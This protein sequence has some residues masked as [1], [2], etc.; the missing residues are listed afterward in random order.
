MTFDD[1]RNRNR[2]QGAG[3]SPSGPAIPGRDKRFRNR[4]S[5][6]RGLE[7]FLGRQAIHG[8][9]A[10]PGRACDFPLPQAIPEMGSDFAAAGARISA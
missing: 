3:D 5:D 7:R 8:G 1:V 9:Q 4:V 10:I 2:F 6:S